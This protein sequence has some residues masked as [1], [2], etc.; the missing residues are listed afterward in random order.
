MDEY[1]AMAA[2]ATQARANLVAALRECCDLADGV[3]QLEGPELLEVLVYLDSLRF[4]MAESG[5][6]LQGVV[7]GFEG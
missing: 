1:D 4:V 7:R 6:L 5:Q 2:R 3:E